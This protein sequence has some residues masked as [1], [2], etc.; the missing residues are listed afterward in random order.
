MKQKFD[1][2]WFLPNNSYLLQ[3]FNQRNKY[4]PDVG[5]DAGIY[6]GEIKYYEEIGKIHDLAMKVKNETEIVKNLDSWTSGFIKYTKKAS[7]ID[8][9][10]DN[11]TEEDFNQHLSQFL[12][13]PNGARFQ[14]NFRFGGTFEC[15]K[16]SPPVV[17]SY[18]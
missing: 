4:Y 8:I 13:S 11:V 17:V 1:P 9:L 10:N 5:K 14:K 16:P 2:E 15:G 3:F 7:G 18:N 6:M 12:W